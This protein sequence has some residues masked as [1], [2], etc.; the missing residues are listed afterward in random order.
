MARHG[1]TAMVLAALAVWGSPGRAYEAQR[2]VDSNGTPIFEVRFFAPADGIYDYLED[3][4]PWALS[5]G[6]KRQILAGVQYWADVIKVVPGQSHAKLNVGTI[7]LTDNAFALS[8]ITG[9]TPVSPTQAAAVLQNRPPGELFHDT[10]G[11]LGVGVVDQSTLPFIPSQIPLDPRWDLPGTVIHEVAHVLGVLGIA[12]DLGADTG[13][14][15]IP[16][17]REI[18]SEYE[19][20]LRDDN[21]NPAHPNQYIACAGCAPPP[22]SDVFDVRQDR[23]YF[24]GDHVSAVLAGAMPGVPVRILD[25]KGKIDHNFLSHL[26]LKSSMMSHQQYGNFASFMEAELAVLQDLGY[27]IDRRNFFG[28]SVYGSGLTLANDNPYFGRNALGTAY[29]PGTYN[30]AMVGLG[31]HVYGSD[32][33]ISQRA[34]LL[35]LGAGGAGIRVDGT[36]NAITIAPGTRV[37]AGGSYGRAVMFTYGKDHTFVQRG[38]VEALGLRGIAASFDFGHNPMGDAMEYRGSYIRTIANQR[39]PLLAELAGPLVGTFD[40]TGRLAGH[41]AAIY[42]SES[43]YVDRVNVMRGAS[44]HGDIL[45]AYSEVDDSGAPRLTTLTFGLLPDADGRST[46]R[47]DAAFAMQYDGNIAGI[48]N[49]SLQLAGGTL[50]APGQHALY[51]VNIAQGATLAGIGRYTLNAAGSFVNHGTVAPTLASAD[52]PASEITVEGNFTQSPTGRLLTMANGAKAFSRLVVNGT[53]ALDGML[54]IAPQRDWYP[55]GFRLTSDAWVSA[56]SV[57]GGFARVTAPLESPTLAASAFALGSG[58]YTLAVSRVAKA[59][60]RYGADSNG[61]RVGTV[62]ER[63]ASVASPDVRPLFAALDFSSP[64]GIDVTSALRQLSPAGYSAMFAGALMRERQITDIVA[65]AVAGDVIGPT[66]AG[67]VDASGHALKRSSSNWRAFA[68]PFGSGYRRGARGSMAGASGKVYGVVLGAEKF[69]GDTRDWTFGAH[70]VISGQSTRLNAETPGSG[71]TTAFDIGV[72]ARYAPAPAAGPHAFA[73]ARVGIEDARMVRKVS[74]NGYT[75]RSRGTWTGAVATASVGAGWRWA[76]GSASS[77]G[78]VVALDYSTLYRPSVTESGGGASLHLR[79]QAFTSLRTRLGGE[80]R[81]DLPASAS[82]ALSANLQATWNR[83]LKDGALTQRAALAAH[84][85]AGFSTRSDVVG[86]DSVGLQAGL[87]YRLGERMVL[88]ASASSNLY[89]TGD[90]DFAGSLKATWRL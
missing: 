47:P 6:H 78:P 19:S 3:V 75:S 15:V 64:D 38:D 59:Y 36:N 18:I 4:S 29:L 50:R 46:G 89:W 34:D 58:H 69:A 7:S 62:L 43:G 14:A 55:D 9:D 37:H 76:L 53:A 85:S 88:G 12:E 61:R 84:P 54:A 48:D 52:G 5:E 24:A 60:S 83:E 33:T 25:G 16:V 80:I 57:T 30:T 1:L 44:L 77:V 66:G 22:T 72:H 32:N 68:V 82:N 67:A 11:V 10:H 31:L 35:T 40:L 17:F 28:H 27:R 79:G 42:L 13:K 49:L 86:R 65:G 21:G 45:S 51:N 23:G 70:G 71:P 56:P 74:V 81:F 41:H 39:V 63:I 87:S 2:I 90:T 20:H 8:P 26:E 73:L